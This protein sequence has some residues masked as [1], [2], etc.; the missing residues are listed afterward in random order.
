MPDPILFVLVLLFG[1]LGTWMLVYPEHVLSLFAQAIAR[2]R[3]TRWI[4]FK[5]PLRVRLTGTMYLAAT[6][7]LIAWRLHTP[8]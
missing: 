5:N 7:A 3:I 6:F 4:F 2:H 8:P 1:G